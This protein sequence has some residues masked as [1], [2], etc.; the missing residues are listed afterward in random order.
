MILGSLIIRHNKEPQSS[1][2][3][4]L[5]PIVYIY[6]LVSV[7]NIAAPGMGGIV[8]PEVYSGDTRK[9]LGIRG[10]GFRVSVNAGKLERGLR[11]ILIL[12][13]KSTRILMFQL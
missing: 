2:D 10:L 6:N 12:H 5:D 13:R 8:N 7:V 1:I 11:M 3:N 4:N 9:G